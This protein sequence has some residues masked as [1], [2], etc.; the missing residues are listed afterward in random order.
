MDLFGLSAFS[1]ETSEGGLLSDRGDD[2]LAFSDVSFEADGF[3]AVLGDGL[4]SL[5]LCFT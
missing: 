4:L 2:L 5:S 3:R 1:F